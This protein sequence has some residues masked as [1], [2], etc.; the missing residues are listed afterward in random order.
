[1][2][3]HSGVGIRFYLEDGCGEPLA[4]RH[5]SL[6]NVRA[7][8]ENRL[9]TSNERQEGSV[10]L[11]TTDHDVGSAIK[12]TYLLVDV[13][14]SIDPDERARVLD[15]FIDTYGSASGDTY[16]KIVA[17]SGR[18]ELLTLTSAC[19]EGFC[20]DLAV[21]HAVVD[22]IQTTLDAWAAYDPQATAAF[23]ATHNAAAD[24]G[25]ISQAH[26]EAMRNVTG[27]RS[28]VG[29]VDNLVIFSDLDDTVGDYSDGLQMA[30][31]T[32]ELIKPSVGA[33]SLVV[34]D[35]PDWYY[36]TDPM[37][38]ANVAEARAAFASVLG[39]DSVF[40]ADDAD[41]LIQAFTDVG[42]WESVTT[43]ALRGSLTL[44]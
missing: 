20:S 12:Y 26:A 31:S 24:I 39:A 21:L 38:V 29:T 34:F 13:S 35:L 5:S 43:S 33:I 3:V 15:S 17:F 28:A 23:W 27:G 4:F 14:M 42:E 8:D 16:M 36:E 7:G 6:F 30:V 25:V 19:E 32:V 40:Q 41:L 37:V 11:V 1:M 18:E 2:P 22:E 44:T 10:S 9:I